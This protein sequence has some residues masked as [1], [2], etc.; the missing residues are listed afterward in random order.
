M[1][2]DNDKWIWW[3]WW[4]QNQKAS[5]PTFIYTDIYTGC[6][7]I[8][9]LHEWFDLMD[10]KKNKTK[11]IVMANRFFSFCFTFIFFIFSYHHTLSLCIKINKYRFSFH[12]YFVRVCGCGCVCTHTNNNQ[13][14]M[15]SIHCFYFC[16]NKYKFNR[17][18]DFIFRLTI[19]FYFVFLL[20]VWE[21]NLIHFRFCF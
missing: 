20:N 8:I 18:V 2:C 14:L 12:I 19:Y 4:W 6:L 5:S 10:Q 13:R 15:I 21:I 7:L 11:S 16:H 9:T 1:I 3:W 17:F